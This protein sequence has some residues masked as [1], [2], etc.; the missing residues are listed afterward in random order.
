[1]SGVVIVGTSVAGVN[2]ARSLRSKGYDGRILL[3]GEELELPY[4]KPPLSK[5]LLAGTRLA[6]D[7]RLLSAEAAAGAG[8]ELLLGQ[9][10]LRLHVAER[11]VELSDNPPV[12]FDHLVIASGAQARPAPWPVESGMHLLRTLEDARSLRADLEHGGPLVVVGGGFIG[13]EVAATARQLGLEVTIVDPI[14][15]PLARVLGEEVGQ[16]LV[17]L[18]RRHGVTTRFGVGVEH[19]RGR[20]GALEVRL[21]DGITLSAAT[22]VVGIGVIPNDAWLT[23]SGLAVEDGV[24]CDEHCRAL[25]GAGAVFAAGDIARWYRRDRGSHVRVEHWTNALE[26]AQCVA[27]N[28]I[29]PQDLRV[30]EP[31]DYVWSDQYD[32]KIQIAGDPAGSEKH[33]LVGDVGGGRFAV[34]Y[35]E[36]SGSLQG[37]LAVNWPRALIDCRRALARGANVH[38]MADVLR[39]RETVSLGAPVP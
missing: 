22:V 21:T 8:I 3:V 6:D 15:V 31:V 20:R 27:H 4:D 38:E 29:N 37:S 25:G 12:S 7:V 39:S 9:R 10:A 26:Q 2:C 16:W 5:E 18:H 33:V 30:F 13:A 32:W 28:L 36:E 14:P 1:M 11:V 34:L 17:D 19:I 23:G 35:A 24:L